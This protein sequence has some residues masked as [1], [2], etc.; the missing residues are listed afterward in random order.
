[1][2]TTMQAK[3]HELNSL[4]RD[5]NHDDATTHNQENADKGLAKQSDTSPTSPAPA[6]PT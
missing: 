2:K 6:A 4:L 5:S 1:M 3:S